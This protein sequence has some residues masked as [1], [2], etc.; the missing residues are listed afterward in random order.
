LGE[1]RILE[2]FHFD[3]WLFNLHCQGCAKVRVGLE[4]LFYE[5]SNLTDFPTGFPLPR[6]IW[7]A[8]PDDPESQPIDTTFELTSTSDATQNALVIKTLTREFYRK[9][10]WCLASNNNVTEAASTNV[11]VDLKRKFKNKKRDE[12]KSFFCI[13]TVSLKL[14]CCKNKFILLGT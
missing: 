3:A 7:Y 11:T 1:A 14:S 8:N 13:F 5:K 4:K 10:F 6:L 12:M 9:T 2:I